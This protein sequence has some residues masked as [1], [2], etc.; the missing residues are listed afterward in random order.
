M[1]VRRMRF[2]PGPGWNPSRNSNPEDCGSAGWGRSPL[3]AGKKMNHWSLFL[4][5]IPRLRLHF[6]LITNSGALS[7]PPLHSSLTP[8]PSA[9]FSCF[10]PFQPVLLFGSWLRGEHFLFFQIFFPQHSPLRSA[11]PG[12][13][14]HVSNAKP[15]RMLSA[16]RHFSV[17]TLEIAAW[18]RGKQHALN[19]FKCGAS[20]LIS[21]H[22]CLQFTAGVSVARPLS[23]REEQQ[24]M[25]HFRTKLIIWLL[26][27]D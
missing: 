11:E 18:R 15:R 16:E 22:R 8:R 24:A 9:S 2:R 20:V 3:Q 1:L 6:S 23:K 27:D 14:F 21:A 10:C 25:K 12:R 7:A 19:A 13:A 4:P 26:K 17:T 5:H